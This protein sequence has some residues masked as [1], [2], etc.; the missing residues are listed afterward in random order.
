MS[1]PQLYSISLNH[2]SD[3]T[4]NASGGTYAVG[5]ETLKKEM[6]ESALSKKLPKSCHSIG[7]KAKLRLDNTTV[8]RD[9]QTS[10]N[11]VKIM[12]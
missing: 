2:V 8:F 5:G 4:K 3:K 10:P 7:G 6:S 12:L 9:A 11:G 1:E